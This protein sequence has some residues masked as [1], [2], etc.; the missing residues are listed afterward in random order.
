MAEENKTKTYEI[1]QLEERVVL[2]GVSERDGDDA[3]DSL[4]ELAELVKTAGATVVGTLIQR[5]ESIHP[6]MYVGT[7]KVQEI[8]EL[9]EQPGATGI[10]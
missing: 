4:V 2:V 8:A 5:R 6:G 1:E 7:G 9:V 3:E 10:V